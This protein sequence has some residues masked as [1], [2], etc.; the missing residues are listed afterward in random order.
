LASKEFILRFVGLEIF[1]FC[2]LCDGVLYALRSP[3]N[4][5][6]KTFARVPF[7][8]PRPVA[9]LVSFS[10]ALSPVPVARLAFPARFLEFHL[11]S[12]YLTDPGPVSWGHQLRRINRGGI[13]LQRGGFIRGAHY[14]LGTK[15]SQTLREEGPRPGGFSR[16]HYL[17][18]AQPSQPLPDGKSRDPQDFGFYGMPVS[19]I[20]SD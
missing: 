11:N 5:F 12:R 10:F 16:K 14:H 6:L 3:K 19:G 1:P 17:R 20:P 2:V 4:I 15:P 9:I 7:S 18:G 8:G 13:R